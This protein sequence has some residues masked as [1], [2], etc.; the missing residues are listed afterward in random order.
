ML[1]AV[2]EIAQG[3]T[4]PRNVAQWSIVMGEVLHE[5]HRITRPG[6]V[7]AFEV[8]EV[9]RGAIKLDELV[10]PLGVA[11]GFACESVLINT[12]KFTKT[13]HIWGVANNSDGTNSN[14]IVV[15]RKP[16]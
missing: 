5:L 16:I 14:R 1:L 2:D 4:V 9:K 13:A 8:G 12:Q 15:F 7:V 10:V 3:I 6:G 11:A